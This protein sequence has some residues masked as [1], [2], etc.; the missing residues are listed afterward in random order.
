MSRLDKNIL[1]HL[2]S[3][4]GKAPQTIKNRLAI[5][6]QNFPKCTM[7]AIAQI[8]SKENGFSIIKKL[9]KEDRESLP[10]LNYEPQHKV[11]VRKNN[12]EKK[13]PVFLVYDSPDYFI[14]GHIKELNN[15]YNSACFTSAFIL[16][17][18][19]VENLLIDI[20]RKK[21]PES[22]N[23][24]NKELYYNILHKRFHDFGIIINNLYKKRNEFGIEGEKIIAR[25]NQLVKPFKNNINDK[26][27]SWF[28]LVEKK[29]EFDDISIHQIIE[30]IIKLEKLVKIRQ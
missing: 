23:N 1:E 2:V 30:L 25:I 17:R 8:F 26:V 14:R 28:H 18:K 29:S 15:A 4:T 5:L 10:N 9:K 6:H 7:N 11:K 20:L 21:F 22:R 12:R 27:H 24:E 19:I 13:K 16:S 3:K